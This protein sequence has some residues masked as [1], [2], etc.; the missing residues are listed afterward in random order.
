MDEWQLV[1]VEPTGAMLKAACKA[2]SPGNKPDEWVSNKE[3]HSI[4]YKAML[5]AAPAPDDALVEFAE[6]KQH[7]ADPA[8][9]RP[10]RA[11]LASRS[12]Q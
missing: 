10:A 11:F 6:R 9:S 3:K 1:P 12:G 7:D 2:M 4:R 8:V 5:A